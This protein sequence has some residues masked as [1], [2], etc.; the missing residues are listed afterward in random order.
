[1]NANNGVFV[2]T[3]NVDSLVKFDKAKVPM[4]WL[5]KVSTKFILPSEISVKGYDKAI[6][7][8]TNELHKLAVLTVTSRMFLIKQDGKSIASELSIG[9]LP[10]FTRLF[11]SGKAEREIYLEIIKE[12]GHEKPENWVQQLY[13]EFENIR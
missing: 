12:Y 11:C 3:V 10:G 9:G 2:S 7:L 13:E 1:M 8:D 4:T 5:D 6:G